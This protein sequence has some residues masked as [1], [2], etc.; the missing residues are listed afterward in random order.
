MKSCTSLLNLSVNNPFLILN[1]NKQTFTHNS[2]KII[3]REWRKS[4]DFAPWCISGHVRGWGAAWIKALNKSAV[5]QSLTSSRIQLA[6]ALIGWHRSGLLSRAEFITWIL[7]GHSVP[8]WW[9]DI[10]DTAIGC[11]VLCGPEGLSSSCRSRCWFI[12]FPWLSLCKQCCQWVK[13]L[14][15]SASQSSKQHCRLSGLYSQ[16]NFHPVF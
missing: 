15:T 14:C 9:M 8:W 4:W 10:S 5:M 11:H 6:T 7:A 2:L 13:I 12:F 3:V 1:Y 16:Q